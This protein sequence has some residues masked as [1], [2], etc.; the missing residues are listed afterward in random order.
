MTYREAPARSPVVSRRLVAEDPFRW[1]KLLLG[2]SMLVG[3]LFLVWTRKWSA[4]DCANEA[5][6]VRQEYRLRAAKEFSFNARSPPAVVVEPTRMGKGGVGKRLVLRYSGGVQV[7]LARDR[8]PGVEAD[9]ARLRSYLQHPKGSFSLGEDHDLHWVGFEVFLALLGLLMSLDGMTLGVWQRIRSDSV[10]HVVTIDRV[11][12]GLRVRRVT[13][14]VTRATT[15]GRAQVTPGNEH[16]YW[17]TLVDPGAPSRR[18]PILDRPKARAIVEEVL[19][20]S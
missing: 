8:G 12:I 18:L 6:V 10:R 14:P 16:F 20:S 19:W 2:L 1:L 4:L 13:Y 11:I 17:L 3:A 7:E 9:A 15:V 5:C